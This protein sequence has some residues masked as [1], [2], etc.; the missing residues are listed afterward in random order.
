MQVSKVYNHLKVGNLESRL[1]EFY[2]IL[3]Q[4]GAAT[5]DIIYMYIYILQN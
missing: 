3:T 2:V 4:T 5:A 1:K